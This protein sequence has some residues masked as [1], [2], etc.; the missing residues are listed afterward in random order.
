M[1]DGVSRCVRQKRKKRNSLR[2]VCLGGENEI[3]VQ[4][5]A[6]AATTAEDELTESRGRL[7]NAIKSS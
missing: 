1:T 5:K 4:A 2:V 3:G 7:L 6:A